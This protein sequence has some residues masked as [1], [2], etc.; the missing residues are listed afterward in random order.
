MTI[1]R[2]LF[3][4][5]LAFVGTFSLTAISCEDVTDELTID[6]PSEVVKTVRFQSDLAGNF[7]LTEKIDLESEEFLENKEKIKGAKVNEITFTVVD[8]LAGG[9]AIPTDVD[10]RFQNARENALTFSPDPGTL[11]EQFDNLESAMSNELFQFIEGVYFDPNS[12]QYD[13]NM[14][15]IFRGNSTGSMDYTVTMTID[16]TLEVGAN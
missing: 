8:N 13:R 14:D 15:L 5:A 11:Q 7:D 3:L 9:S 16:V 2:K 12:N 10:F 6:V 1:F 4:Y